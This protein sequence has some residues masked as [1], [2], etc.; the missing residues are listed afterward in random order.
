MSVNYWLILYF[1]CYK[2]KLLLQCNII[3]ITHLIV[4]FWP[5]II[6]YVALYWQSFLIG[7]LV[8]L[9]EGDIMKSLLLLFRADIFWKTEYKSMQSQR[10]LVSLTKQLNLWQLLIMYSQTKQAYGK[11]VSLSEVSRICDRP[12]QILCSHPSH[13]PIKLI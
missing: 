9:W 12:I 2:Q 5:E 1:L 3:L 6:C 10:I 4:L 13:L 7:T 8:H 11:G